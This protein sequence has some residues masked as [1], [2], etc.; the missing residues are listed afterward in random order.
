MLILIQ[1]LELTK[2]FYLNIFWHIYLSLITSRLT[3]LQKLDCFIVLYFFSFFLLH[4]I[5]LVAVKYLNKEQLTAWLCFH[6]K[7]WNRCTE[8]L[9]DTP[10]QSQTYFVFECQ[11]LWSP[12]SQ[13][14]RTTKVLAQYICSVIFDFPYWYDIVTALFVIY[15]SKYQSS[16]W[17]STQ[18]CFTYLTCWHR[19]RGK[20]IL[21]YIYMLHCIYV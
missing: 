15:N 20:L 18:H 13:F 21:F 17:Y 6:W 1:T 14:L 2:F 5:E 9:K 3:C 11:G 19:I 16:R 10:M 7:H 8:L 4:T 12:Y